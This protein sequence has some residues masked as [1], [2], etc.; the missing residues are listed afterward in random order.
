M[1][2]LGISCFYHDSAAAIIIDGKIKAAAEEERF[3]RK[4]HDRNFP[5]NSI[6]YCLDELK[7]TLEEVD[8]IVFYDKPILKFDRILESY[9]TSSPHGLKQFLKSI[10]NWIKEKIFFK[11]LVSKSLSLIAPCKKLFTSANIISLMQLLHFFHHLIEMLQ[12]CA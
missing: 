5:H 11:R 6:K 10:P 4:K 2:V 12:F 8:S 1:I 7:I 9:F 3:T